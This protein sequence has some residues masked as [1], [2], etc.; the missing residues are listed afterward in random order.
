[1]PIV[2]VTQLVDDSDGVTVIDDS[3]PYVRLRDDSTGQ[4][5]VFRDWNAVAVWA[6]SMQ[7][8]LDAAVTAV[9]V[10]TNVIDGPSPEEV[11]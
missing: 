2:T 10:Q 7:A 5:Y 11:V 1:M 6:P 4:L 9:Q 8:A 3:L